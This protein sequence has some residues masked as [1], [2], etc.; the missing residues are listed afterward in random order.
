MGTETAVVRY[1]NPENHRFFVGGLVGVV[2]IFGLLSLMLLATKPTLAVLPAVVGAV[3]GLLLKRLFRHS[4][5]ESG[6]AGL[7]VCN[8]FSEHGYDWGTIRAIGGGR[9][10][11]IDLKAGGHV[12]AWA[13]QNSNWNS[14]RNEPGYA[15]EVAASI[16]ASGLLNDA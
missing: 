11:R 7:L 10:L 15:D 16:Q 5:V 14:I 13:V 6:P 1:V 12:Y 2:A 4:Y 3:M 9:M 8:P